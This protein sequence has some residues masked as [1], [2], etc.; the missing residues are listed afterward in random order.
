M[1]RMGSRVGHHAEVT[2]RP[3]DLATQGYWEDDKLNK[4]SIR[5]DGRIFVILSVCCSQSS[6]WP[7]NSR[8]DPS[9]TQYDSGMFLYTSPTSYRRPTASLGNGRDTKRTWSGRRND[10]SNWVTEWWNSAVCRKWTVDAPSDECMVGGRSTHRWW[11]VIDC[12][13]RLGEASWVAASLHSSD[14][15]NGLHIMHQV[16]KNWWRID[17]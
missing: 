10:G 9:H 4:L 3:G 7:G 6:V 17:W 11:S 1:E 8:P 14:K 2:W 5:L 13:Q 15:V 12:R 16:P